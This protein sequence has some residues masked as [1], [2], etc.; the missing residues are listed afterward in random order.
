[1]LSLV[2]LRRCRRDIARSRFDLSVLLQDQ[3][4][5]LV[6]LQNAPFMNH[7]ESL[8]FRCTFCVL[9]NEQVNIWYPLSVHILPLH[10]ARIPKRLLYFTTTERPLRSEMR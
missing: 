6:V 1:M 7:I 9:L 10:R 2:T 4:E 8:W 3:L 5:R